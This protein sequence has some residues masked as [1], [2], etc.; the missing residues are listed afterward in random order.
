[1]RS[2][3]P[4][5]SLPSL[6]VAFRETETREMKGI[7]HV[8]VNALSTYSDHAREATLKYLSSVGFKVNKKQIQMNQRG[9]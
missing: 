7:T 2:S 5:L 6:L 9:K 1:M 3:N 8:P 4:K